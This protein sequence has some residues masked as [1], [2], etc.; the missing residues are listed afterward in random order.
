MFKGRDKKK[1]EGV[2]APVIEGELTA[3]CVR[4]M[5]QPHDLIYNSL[6]RECGNIGNRHLNA[7][8]YIPP[9][10][11]R[12]AYVTFEGSG[13]ISIDRTI[14]EVCTNGRRLDS[15][16]AR[17]HVKD[18]LMT[19][20]AVLID[21]SAQM[22]AEW[23]SKKLEYTVKPEEA[24]QVLAKLATISIMES[25]GRYADY[26]DIVIFGDDADGPFN[27]W[28]FTHKHLL[29][30]KG[31]GLSRLDL[32]LAKLLQIEWEMRPGNRYLFI[33]GGGLP[34][35]GTNIL[36]DDMEVQVNV[37]YYLQ[38]MIRQGVKAAYIPFFTREDLL[39]E[40]IGAFSAR[41]F[42]EKMKQ[43][44]V[45]VAQIDSEPSLPAGLRKGFRNMM[46]GPKREMPV[47]EQ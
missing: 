4:Y 17:T 44:G 25:L 33:L 12:T 10:I 31:K 19:S 7:N 13:S 23:M 2:Q 35:T 39:D 28:Q 42:A 40:R 3:R 27:K 21:N 24:P 30:L 36:L 46:V 45:S 6:L 22:T 8:F 32:G 41:G 43:I 18:K 38:R 5:E 47:F 37:F 34:S 29:K 26:I 20:L 14:Q 15:I 9:A 1:T 11:G 16:R